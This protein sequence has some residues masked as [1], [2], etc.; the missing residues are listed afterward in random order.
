MSGNL[1]LHRGAREASI[2]QVARVETPSP[3]DTW[4][5]IPHLAVLEAVEE[6]LAAGQDSTEKQ[7]AG[8]RRQGADRRS[9]TD[10]EVGEPLARDGC[11]MRG[12]HRG[13]APRG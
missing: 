10:R 12:C 8:R 3:T 7:P 5:P 6:T 2:D 1:I 13:P 4:F 11:R 9:S